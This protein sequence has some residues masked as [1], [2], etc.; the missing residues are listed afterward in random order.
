MTDDDGAVPSLAMPPA[1]ER[2]MPLLSPAK[3]EVFNVDEFLC[4]R[5]HGQD[6]PSILQELRTYKHSLQDSLVQLINEKYRD[7]V[8]L[9][10]MIHSDANAIH[11]AGDDAEVQAIRKSLFETRDMLAAT[12]T[13][14]A[15]LCAEGKR[16]REKKVRV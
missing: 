3:K 5:A 9:A 11:E 6:V 12:E 13:S 7:F 2:G 16:E 15:Q 10:T 4:S 8:S 1:L 14:F